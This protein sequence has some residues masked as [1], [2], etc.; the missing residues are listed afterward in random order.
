MSDDRVVAVISIGSDNLNGL[1]EQDL[2]T[3]SSLASH[4][5]TVIENA[6]L[7]HNID[8][9]S[10]KLERTVAARTQRLQAVKGI[11]HVVS[12]GLDIN[13]L[14]GVVGYEISQIFT[15]GVSVEESARVMIGLVQGSNLVVRTTNGL[16]GDDDEGDRPIE[17][18]RND[19]M[20][21]T[22][23][24]LNMQTPVG[25]VIGQ[26]KP[27][28]L[29]NIDPQDIY[30][31]ASD[32]GQPN[33]IN[34]LMMAPLITAGKT[35]GLIT[36][37]SHLD[38]AF[39][40]SDLES[41]ESVAFQVATGIE[42]ARLLQKTRELA[43]VDERTR[44]ARDM[45][46]GVAQN[47]AYLLIQVD[48]SLNLVEEDSKLEAQLELIGRVLKQN[49]DE[50]RRNIFD[51]RPVDLEGKSLFEVLENFV[52][53]FGRRWNLR[54]SCVVKGEA[55][56]VSP[57]VE[58]CLYRILQE[59]LS[60][61]RQH[62]RCKQLWVEVVLEQDKMVSLEVTDDGR[63]FEFGQASH[64]AHNRNGKGLGLVSMRERAEDVGGRLTVESVKGQGTRIYA[65]LPLISSATD[66][67][68]GTTS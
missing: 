8:S 16:T 47:L 55:K 39:D 9:Y 27:I 4:A 41:L 6:R 56:Q 50:L 34:S 35:I 23:Y 49:I 30:G 28:I 44:L 24:R 20:S 53:E 26:S 66:N 1:G 2:W 62:A 18:T 61:A 40:E 63:G 67:R 14:L 38:D 57:E 46:D 64:D 17:S 54:T 48:R 36:V 15:P 13:E 7:Y 11:S 59:S 52:T 37:E 32:T 19:I 12:Q 33:D 58:R 10:E 45:H 29:Q 65:E 5:A 22:E 3:L 51:L 43:I 68:D 60:N 21:E 42:H 25:Q 31:N